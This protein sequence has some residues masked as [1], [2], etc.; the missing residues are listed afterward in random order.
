MAI[1]KV[2]RYKDLKTKREALYGNI[3]ELSK[4]ETIIIDGVIISEY[5]LRRLLAKGHYIDEKV[6]IKKMNI[7]RS[8]FK[9]S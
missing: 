8:K 9:K 7:Q 5:K 2:W 3:R 6:S 1:D 4:S